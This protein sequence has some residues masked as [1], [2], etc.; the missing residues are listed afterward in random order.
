MIS[1]RWIPSAAVA[2]LVHAALFV[3]SGRIRAPQEA[4]PP[5]A[6]ARDEVTIDL[7]EVP[8]APVAS[9]SVERSIGPAGA[10]WGGERG[11]SAKAAPV[12]APDLEG[13]EPPASEPQVAPAPSDEGW[14]FNPMQAPDVTSPAFVARSVADIVRDPGARPT[15]PSAGRL[16][17]ALDQR[18]VELG[19]GRGGPVLT[20]LEVA[21]RSSDVP[22]GWALF[23]VAIDTAGRMSVAVGDVSGDHAAWTK[24]ASTAAASFDPARMRVPPGSR[25]WRVVV[26]VDA[27][28]QYPDGRKPKD[29]GTH[30]EATPGKLSSTSM[31]MEKTPGFSVATQGK[32]CG[33]GLSMHL[34]VPMIAG[35]CDPENAGMPAVR[36]VSGHIVSEGRL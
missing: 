29:L 2:A 3:A 9:T 11:V 6:E 17:E 25:G 22:E 30:F 21:T 28:V 36:I 1:R 23:D 4:S 16:A 33:I 27:K 19:I 8:R 24:V 35:G 14:S 18:D 5:I 13:G 15:P 31:V 20:A 10:P 34:P 12:A 7:A 26:R 32:V